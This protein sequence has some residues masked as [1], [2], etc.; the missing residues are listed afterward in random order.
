MKY[1]SPKLKIILTMI[2]WG[3]IG[4]FVRNISLTSIEI[5]FFRAFIGSLFLSLIA[6]INKEKMNKEAL[7]ENFLILLLSGVALG[8]N[9]AALFQAMKYTTISN[10]TLSYYF[11]P[12]F[13]V[14]FSTL[15]LKEKITIKNSMCILVSILGLFLILKSN[16][17]GGA[18]D[19]NHLKGVLFGLGGAI[20]YAII[21]ILNK[22]IKDLSPLEITL[23]QLAISAIVLLPIVLKAGI[24]DIKGLDINTWLLILILGIIHTGIAYLFY[25]PSIRDVEAQTIAIISYL[26]PITAI[27][28]SAI[29][30][31]EPMTG[32]Q[33]IGGSLI[34]ASAYVNERK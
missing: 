17:S 4:L 26:D 29:F 28:V 18:S 2:T 15:I 5:S 20:L 19:Y 33:L 32:I 22:F 31:K 7:K 16:S 6:L 34:L 9:W 21:V 13:I 8:V 12:V 30:L 3:T 11:A 10:A 23:T 14:I 25:F 27:I 1:I 24:G